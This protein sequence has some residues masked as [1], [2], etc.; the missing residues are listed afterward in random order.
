[1]NSQDSRPGRPPFLGLLALALTAGVAL[2]S[3]PS[4]EW[5]R[6]GE[7]IELRKVERE[8]V[9]AAGLDPAVGL[10]DLTGSF[11]PLIA[12]AGGGL[13]GESLLNCKE[14]LDAS[15]ER[16]FRLFELDFSF[17]TD[18]QLVLLHDWDVTF[19]RLF[20]NPGGPLDLGAF[21][22]R[23]MSGG[24][25][26][27]EPDSLAAWLREHPEA[28]VVTDVKGDTLEALGILLA[29]HPWLRERLIPQ[30]YRLSEYVPVRRLG[31][32]TVILTL[33][34]SQYDDQTVLRFASSASLAAVTMDYYR[35]YWVLP[36]QLRAAG[37]TVLAHTVNDP[38]MARR[39]MRNGVSGFYTDNLDPRT[40]PETPRRAGPRR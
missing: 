8:L 10:P 24:F 18:R 27:L 15:W 12:H 25:S 11:V 4:D 22:K 36:P 20:G 2:W 16:G 32:R 1:V 7:R 17:T 30:I 14:A 23:R 19:T 21:R 31:L 35:A 34:V 28:Y 26:P 5:K 39:L 13:D 9:H 33:Y 40:P 6:L 3:I 38:L 29:R 37:V